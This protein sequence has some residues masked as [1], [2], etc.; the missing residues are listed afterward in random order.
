MQ[1]FELNEKLTYSFLVII[2]RELQLILLE[3]AVKAILFIPLYSLTMINQLYDY[4][5]SRLWVVMER[6]AP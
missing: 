4:M 3:V 6:S 1:F 5:M 2:H